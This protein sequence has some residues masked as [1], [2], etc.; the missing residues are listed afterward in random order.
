MENK[1]IYTDSR[2]N[3]YKLKLE[4]KNYIEKNNN[5]LFLFNKNLFNKKNIICDMEMNGCT[6]KPEILEISCIKIKNGKIIDDLFLESQITTKLRKK[7]KEL[8]GKDEEYYKNKNPIEE[9]FKKIHS[10]LGNEC[11]ICFYSPYYD[12]LTLKKIYKNFKIKM[13]KF[14]IIDGN[15]C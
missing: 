14:K 9:N 2:I 8:L 13:P 11:Y 7:V 6:Y 15:S 5:Q 10:F 3:F 12:I 4:I 1:N